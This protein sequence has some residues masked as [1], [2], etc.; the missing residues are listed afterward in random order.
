M[1]RI[2]LVL[3]HTVETEATNEAQHNQTAYRKDWI[4]QQLIYQAR[5]FNRND[6][7][8]RGFGRGRSSHHRC[9]G[10][11]NGSW[12]CRRYSGWGGRRGGCH[13]SRRW[14]NRRLGYWSGSCRSR[15]CRNS[16]TRFFQITDI[17]SKF[18]ST[19][20]RIFVSPL[21]GQLGF[22]VFGLNGT[23]RQR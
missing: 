16:C 14:Y 12:R 13:D 1:G 8:H 21:L 10:L 6:R 2:F 9:R 4:F 23:L 5:F 20:G 22:F 3:A 19:G 11:H 18:G 7:R 15:R 17:F